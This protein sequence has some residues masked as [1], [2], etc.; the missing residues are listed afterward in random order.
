MTLNLSYLPSLAVCAKFAHTKF[1]VNS[2]S[3]KMFFNFPFSSVLN[4]N[5]ALLF[6]LKH[7]KNLLSY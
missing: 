4:F 2:L 1:S 6:Q 3:L 7:K 5:I